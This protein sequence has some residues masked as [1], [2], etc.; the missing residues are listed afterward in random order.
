MEKSIVEE[1]WL[2]EMSDAIQV[3]IEKFKWIDF[4]ENIKT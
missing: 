4:D 1:I 2:D 3:E